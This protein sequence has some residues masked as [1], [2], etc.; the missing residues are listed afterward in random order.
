MVSVSRVAGPPHF[1]QAAA[2]KPSWRRS[3]DSPDAHHFT[4]G[5]RHPVGRGF[6]VIGHVSYVRS[7]GS[8]TAGPHD[9]VSA[10]L[11]GYADLG[12]GMQLL[13]WV[14]AS[15]SGDSNAGRDDEASNRQI[16]FSLVTRF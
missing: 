11:G 14:G 16:A 15:A 12:K 9:A 4:V 8:A 2:R 10:A 6:G 13:A 7:L 1:G 3:G 5:G